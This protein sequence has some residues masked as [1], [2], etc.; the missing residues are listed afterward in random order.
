MKAT[1]RNRSLWDR[2]NRTGPPLFQGGGSFYRPDLVRLPTYRIGYRRGEDENG[3]QAIRLYSRI[4]ARQTAYFRRD[5]IGCPPPAY[6]PV[7]RRPTARA[8]LAVN[9]AL[10]DLDL[11]TNLVAIPPTVIQIAVATIADDTAALVAL[12]NFCLQEEIIDA[13]EAYANLR[14]LEE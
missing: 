14:A 6:I 10:E 12:F 4:C 9:K 13:Q 1:R 3:D 8:I 7:E 5:F 11:S 2:C